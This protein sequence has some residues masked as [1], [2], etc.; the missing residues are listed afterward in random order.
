MTI[1]YATYRPLEKEYKAL[2]G[3]RTFKMSPELK[4]VTCD[5]CKDKYHGKAT[6]KRKK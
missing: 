2:C 5:K 4:D 6:K 3:V 1:H